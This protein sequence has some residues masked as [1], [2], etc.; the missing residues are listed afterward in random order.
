MK[1][2][3]LAN[4]IPPAL[5]LICRLVLAALFLY[6][7]VEKIIDPREF[8]KAIYFYQ[9]VPDFAVNLMA[10]VLPVLEII[11]AL[12]L[13]SGIYLRG[14]SLISSCLFLL[15]AAALSI[16]LFRGLDISCGCFGKSSGSINWLYLV[17][18][19]SLCLMSLWILFFDRGWKY[20]LARR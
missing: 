17:R 6:A 9:I 7:A 15:F 13:I 14:A 1:L 18:D 4:H 3:E 8:A 20:L 11:L 12:S 5:A 10:V 16:S 2:K 19:I